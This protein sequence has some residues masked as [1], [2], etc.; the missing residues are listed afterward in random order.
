MTESKEAKSRFRPA[1][2]RK[3]PINPT[4]GPRV[5]GFYWN[6]STIAKALCMHRN[7]VR[8]KLQEAGIEPD[9]YVSNSPVFHLGKA[10]PPLF[11]HPP[12][13][14]KESPHE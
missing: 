1:K 8:K 6:T 9:G 5:N 7:T 11:G 3:L 10:I 13:S 2:L 12:R 14:P 4:H